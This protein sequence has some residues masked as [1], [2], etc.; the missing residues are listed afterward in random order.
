MK[1]KYLLIILFVVV[2]CKK[3]NDAE[4]LKAAKKFQYKLNIEFLDKKSSPLKEEN[5]KQ[6]KGLDYFPIQ[7]KYRIKANF[8]PT[9]NGKEF[10]MLTTTSRLAKYIKYGVAYFTFEDKNLKLSIYQNIEGVK[11]LFLPYFDKT[12]GKENYSG[13]KYI[14]INEPVDNIIII[15][16]NQS[17]NPY[18]AYN[19]K[20]SCPIPPDE[21]YLD[22]EIKAGV[23][24]FH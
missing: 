9:P 13:G 7:Y 19:E 6:F 16:F 23:K 3:D 17:Y 18:C 24:K 11:H 4:F 2:N 14:E 21:N 20:Y 22:V 10:D 12:S 8:M 5:F 15:D 1:I